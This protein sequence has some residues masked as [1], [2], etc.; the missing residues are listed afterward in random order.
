MGE[1]ARSF[2]LEHG[3]RR[4]EMDRMAD[5]YRALVH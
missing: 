5:M 3:D 2:V 1:A 4:K